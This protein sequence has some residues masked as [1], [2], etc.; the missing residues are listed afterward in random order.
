[1]QIPRT[2]GAVSGLL[3][4]V[5][6][7]WGAVIPFV[8]PYF[9]LVIGSDQTWDWTWGRFWLSILPGA[10]AFFGGLLLLTS[11]HRARAA[12]GAWLA[13]AG[14]VWFVIGPTLS[15]LWNDGLSATGAAAGDT[16]RRVLELLTMYLGLG[17]LIATLGAFALGR[18]MVRGVRDAE[19]AREA[20][21]ERERTGATERRFRR[22]RTARTRDADPERT[23]GPVEPVAARESAAGPT[24]PVAARESAGPSAPTT[25]GDEPTRVSRTSPTPAANAPAE[26]PRTAPAPRTEPA[27]TGRSGGLL[28][29][30]RRS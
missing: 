28:G 30:L 23:G 24:E 10:A 29:R 2:R 18:L 22:D 1:M 4:I 7:V 13:I 20:E 17:V 21:L 3:L 19:L 9:G 16:G 6:G 14:G 15:M 8:G 25:T 11:A 5:L 12:I 27:S 26:S